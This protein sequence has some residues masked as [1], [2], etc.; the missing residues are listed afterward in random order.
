MGVGCA[1]LGEDG[2][3]S[4]IQQHGPAIGSD[5]DVFRFEIGVDDKM[6]VGVLDGLADIEKKLDT[7]GQRKLMVVAVG[8]DGD[9]VDVVHDDITQA[10]LS[11]AQVEQPDDAWMLKRC[12][13]FSFALQFRIRCGGKEMR[14]QNLD[15]DLLGELFH[16][17]A[18]ID[19]AHS[20][21]A[22]KARD[23]KRAD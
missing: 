20:S 16:S 2:R 14:M 10:A 19:D 4:E 7:A 11:D 9:A 13:Q 12:E 17:F 15:G 22:E 23:A 6:P 3:H 1:K 21:H 18:E 8:I 5:E